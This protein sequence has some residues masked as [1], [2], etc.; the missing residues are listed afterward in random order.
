MP[1]RTIAASLIMSVALLAA[2]SRSVAQDKPFPNRTVRI[3]VP[4]STGSSLDV[5]AREMAQRLQDVWNVPVVVE[6]RAGAGNSIGTEH[7][8]KSAPDGYTWL[9]AP[10]N[11]LTVNPHL[12]KNAG[13]P[14]KDFAPVTTVAFVPFLIV[15]HPSVPAR[16]VKELV[17]LAKANPG[18]LNYGSTGSGS[19][20]H[21]ATELFKLQAGVDLVH[22]PYKTGVTVITDLLSG[23]LQIYFGANNALLPHVKA[24]T[25]RALAVLGPRRDRAQADIPTIAEA[26]MPEYQVS[27]WNSVVVP[28]GVPAGVIARIHGEIVKTLTTPEIRNR[29]ATQG[30]EVQTSSPE[31]FGAMIRNEHAMYGKLIKELGIKSD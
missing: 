23:R 24:G 19:A 16:T 13:D 18:T 5:S 14:L 11:V 7:V 17:A 26:G 2:P 3:V 4:G 9:L 22:V 21:L 31:E 15:V 30:I 29:L 28:A 25:L 27:T 10:Y 8:A 20:Q 1:F 12:L 6:N